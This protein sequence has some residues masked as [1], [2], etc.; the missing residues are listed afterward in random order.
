LDRDS[1]RHL[2]VGKAAQRTGYFDAAAKPERMLHDD[3]H[4]LDLTISFNKGPLYYFGQL[5]LPVSRRAL[6]PKPGR[7]GNPNPAIHTTISTL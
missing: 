3:R 2:G 4:I 7:P 1:E 6:R 5:Q